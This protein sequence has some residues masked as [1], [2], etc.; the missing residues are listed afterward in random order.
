[1]INHKLIKLKVPRGRS[2]YHA[3]CRAEGREI[4]LVRDWRD[5]DCKQCLALKPK[6]SKAKK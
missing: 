4:H 2:A 3:V 6:T 5:V 1:M